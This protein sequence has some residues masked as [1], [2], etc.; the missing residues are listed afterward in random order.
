MLCTLV[1]ADVQRQ[2]WLH[3][4]GALPM[5]YRLTLAQAAHR[6]G[7]VDHPSDEGTGS[8]LQVCSVADRPKSCLGF[9]F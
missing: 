8:P 3:Q 2:A 5:L 7:V 9:A 4:A 6:Q 1:A